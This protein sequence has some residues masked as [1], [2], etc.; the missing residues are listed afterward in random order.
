MKQKVPENSH[1]PFPEIFEIL[2]CEVQDVLSWEMCQ[3][4]QAKFKVMMYVCMYLC[5]LLCIL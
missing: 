2:K 1:L 5:G 3:I 4:M